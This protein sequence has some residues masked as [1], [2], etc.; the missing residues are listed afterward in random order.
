[1]ILGTAIFGNILSSMTNILAEAHSGNAARQAKLQALNSFMAS[2]GLPFD[3]QVRIRRFFRFFWQRSLTT[4]VAE[5]ELLEQLSMPLRQE[6]TTQ[7]LN[8]SISTCARRAS[9]VRALSCV[10]RRSRSCTARCTRYS[11]TPRAS[12][13]LDYSLLACR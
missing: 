8:P 5:D 1:M 11:P 9:C 13:T 4:D 6:V 10:D 2:K 12:P 7:R 3:L